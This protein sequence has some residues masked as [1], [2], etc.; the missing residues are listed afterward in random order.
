MTL[1]ERVALIIGNLTIQI[2]QQAVVIE[3]QAKQIED[4]NVST[5]KE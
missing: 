2:Q 1:D 4:I 5:P 3:Q